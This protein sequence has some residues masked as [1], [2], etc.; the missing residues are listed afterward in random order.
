[1][2]KIVIIA[3]AFL[4]LHATGQEGGKNRDFKQESGKRMADFSAEEIASLQTKK[5]TLHLDL[6]ASQQTKIQKL[7]LENA[8]RR[9]AMMEARK[10]RKASGKTEKL[11]KEER[12]EMMNTRLDNQI[13]RKAEL[14]TILNPE[15]FEKWE[16]HQDMNRKKGKNHKKRFGGKRQ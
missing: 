5:M 7:N 15:Q 11:S 16:K 3:V 10:A 12:L 13:A 14:K 4:A 9:K 2:K 6:T 1:M 8:T